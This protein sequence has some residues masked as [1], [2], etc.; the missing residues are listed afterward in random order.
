MNPIEH[1]VGTWLC[2]YCTAGNTNF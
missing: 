1:N 2:Y